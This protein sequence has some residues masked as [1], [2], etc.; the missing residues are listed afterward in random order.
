[1]RRLTLDGIELL[2]AIARSGS[3]SGAGVLLNKVTS[4][5]SYSVAKLESDLDVALFHRNGPKV[6]LTPAGRELLQEGRVLLR[7]AD[8]LECRVKRVADGWENEV[9]IAVDSLIPPQMFGSLFE[10]FCADAPATRVKLM[11]EAMTGPW[12]ALLDGRADIIVAVGQ[13]PSGGGFRSKKLA[14]LQFAYCVAPRH[15]LAG[16]NGAVPSEEGRRHRTIVVSDT[17]RRMPVRTVGLLRGQQVLAVPD[18]RTKYAL[19]V[20]GLGVGFLPRLFVSNALKKGLLVEKQVEEPKPDDQVLL[21]WRVG[22]PGKALKWWRD[23]LGES[24]VVQQFLNRASQAW[25][26]EY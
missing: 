7:A 18:M 4:T 19:Q 9:R 25:T 10:R 2:D 20:A 23:L 24:D 8:D 11:S 17:A 21:A 26:A 5:V 1:M 12:E 13:G 16:W 6:G 14:E 22:E 3:F 15:P